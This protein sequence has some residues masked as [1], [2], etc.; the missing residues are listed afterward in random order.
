MKSQGLV[1]H[2]AKEGRGEYDFF[3]HQGNQSEYMVG[4]AVESVSYDTIQVQLHDKAASRQHCRIFCNPA[5]EWLV[6]D[7]GS[8][9]GTWIRKD[10]ED[11]GDFQRVTTPTQ[12]NAET[13][14]RIGESDVTVTELPISKSS[15]AAEYFVDNHHEQPPTIH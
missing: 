5:S 7:L 1:F 14:I 2:V 3:Y 13:I 8:S 6:E 11:T 4:R 15:A 10:T 9:N 12:I